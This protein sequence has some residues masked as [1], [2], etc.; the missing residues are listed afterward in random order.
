MSNA[1]IVRATMLAVET[2][3]STLDPSKDALLATSRGLEAIVDRQFLTTLQGYKWYAVI[4]RGHIYAVADIRGHRISLQRFVYL[5]A[6]PTFTLDEVR[7]VSF[8]NKISFDCR[9]ANLTDRIGR[10]AVMR[11]RRPKRGTSSVYKGVMAIKKPDGTVRWKTQIKAD[12]GSMSIGTYPDEQ[13]AAKVYDAAAFLLFGGAALYNFPGHVPDAET[14]TQVARHVA[15]R[16]RFVESRAQD[17][18]DRS[19]SLSD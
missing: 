19:A 18:I 8:I 7:H 6:D 13:Q 12:F 1:E 11:N 14:L 4:P 15:R 9:L 16:K 10:Q 2:L 5:L 17:E 3:A